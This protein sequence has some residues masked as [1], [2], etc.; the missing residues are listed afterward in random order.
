MPSIW[1]LTQWICLCVVIVSLV[2]CMAMAAV[3]SVGL[4]QV[5]VTALDQKAEP[6][7]HLIPLVKQTEALPDYRIVINT[8][9]GRRINLGARP[10]QS[11]IDGLTW[12]LSD[13]ISI[14]EIASIRLEDQDKLVS[15]AIV[16][17]QLSSEA[18]TAGNY[19]FEFLTERS[20]A[21]GFQ[22]FFKTPVGI[23][24]GTAFTLAVLLILLM[25]FASLFGGVVG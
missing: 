13:P 16:E 1:R 17:V 7:D 18:V 12:R 6:R 19:K 25:L 20:L 14:D 5:T 15:D 2:A 4:T 21:V 24:I 22:S 10:N 8:T 3:R 9:T 11:A 23:A